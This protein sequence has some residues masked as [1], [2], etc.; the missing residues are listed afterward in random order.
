MTRLRSL[1]KE[2]GWTAFE[3]ARR[4][5]VNPS[6]DISALELGRKT[7]PAGSPALRRLARALG[8]TGDP[9]ALL[10]EVDDGR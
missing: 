5:R 1:R 9:A 3:L 7:P 4:S 8:W 10:E 6:S 2:R